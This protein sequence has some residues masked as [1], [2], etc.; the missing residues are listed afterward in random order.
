MKISRNLVI[1]NTIK[2]GNVDNCNMIMH[3]DCEYYADD[4][5]VMRSDMLVWINNYYFHRDTEHF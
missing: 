4:G 1:E 2:W 3:V 5:I